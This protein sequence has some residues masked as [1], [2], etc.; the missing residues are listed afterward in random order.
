MR[1]Y[2]VPVA[3][4]L[5]AMPAAADAPTD[6]YES[7]TNKSIIIHDKHTGLY[8]DRPVDSSH[9]VITPDPGPYAPKE[10]FCTSVAGRR[11]PTIKELM[12][13]FDEAPH[14]VADTSPSG[15]TGL[16]VDSRAFPGM[17]YQKPYWSSTPD[18]SGKLWSLDFNTG[19]MVALDPVNG[20]GTVRCVQ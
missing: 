1:R 14:E 6:Q 13:L 17:A 15:K 10:S 11:V 12:T 18:G 3:L 16:Y 7:F 8:W 2:L 19:E 5:V 20:V 4:F 9:L